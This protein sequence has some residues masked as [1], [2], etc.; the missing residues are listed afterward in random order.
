MNLDHFLTAKMAIFDEI[1]DSTVNAFCRVSLETRQKAH[2][3]GGLISF[4]A[5]TGLQ[6]VH[7]SRTLYEYANGGNDTRGKSGRGW[8]GCHR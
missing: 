4:I 8:A 3:T 7:H 6:Y 2:L 1:M 5:S